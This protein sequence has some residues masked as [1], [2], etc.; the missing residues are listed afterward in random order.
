MAYVSS[1]S[2]TTIQA[3]GNYTTTNSTLYPEFWVV[4]QADDQDIDGIPDTWE[5]QIA[6]KFKPVLHKHH[7]DLQKD[8]YNF[9]MVLDNRSTLWA[10]WVQTENYYNPETEEWEVLTWT[11]EKYWRGSP[12]NLHVVG[13]ETGTSYKLGIPVDFPY[14]WVWDSFQKM[15]E[16]A[17]FQVQFLLDLDDVITFQNHSGAPV[18]N[19]P[20]YYHIYKSGD[21]YYL[22][23]WYYLTMNDLRNK[24]GSG[25]WHES[26][27]EHVAIKLQKDGN[28]FTP[29][30]V[31]FYIHTGGQTLSPGSCWW[32][33]SNATTYSGIQQGYDEGH[34]HLHIW[35]AANSH[36]SY[37]RYE[38]THRYHLNLQWFPGLIFA[39]AQDNVDYS[40]SGYDEYFPYDFLEKLGETNREDL[41][42]PR[43]NSKYW[44]AFE[45]RFGNYWTLYA[46]WILR[47]FSS[48]SP[49]PITMNG[50]DHEYYTFTNGDFG[51]HWG[52]DNPEGE[53]KGLSDASIYWNPDLP[54]GD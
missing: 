5:E 22:Q 32:S 11:H 53:I 21:Y 34:T 18:G 25:S 51:S 49:G 52:F 19:R 44:I 37:N 2:Y 31:N 15:N 26:D 39:N 12:L 3:T 40:P 24:D 27:W 54:D 47:T 50:E 9:E 41:V 30:A 46:W 1:S 23:Y 16:N 28:N 17:A 35:L 48:P 29:V 6:E 38:L 43:G 10:T 14:T 8:L 7:E 20:L 42:T 13:S 33:S 36:A 4:S 45:G